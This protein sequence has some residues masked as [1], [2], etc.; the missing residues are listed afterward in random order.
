M[1]LEVLIAGWLRKL[2]LM[3]QHPASDRGKEAAKVI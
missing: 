1:K 2:C 3:L